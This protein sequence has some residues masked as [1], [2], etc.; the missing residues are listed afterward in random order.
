MCH[1]VHNTLEFTTRVEVLPVLKVAKNLTS[2]SQDMLWCIGKNI[3]LID[4]VCGHP[5]IALNVP[6]QFI[7]IGNIST[8]DSPALWRISGHYSGFIIMWRMVISLVRNFMCPFIVRQTRHINT[9]WCS[10]RHVGYT[11]DAACNAPTHIGGY[12][13][14]YHYWI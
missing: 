12:R 6:H 9:T 11:I 10:D 7:D 3:A 8:I 5:N 1:E 14:G 4:K 2:S 13:V